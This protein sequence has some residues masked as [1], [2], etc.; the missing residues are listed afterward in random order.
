MDSKYLEKVKKILKT[1]TEKEA[2][3]KIAE[4]DLKNNKISQS[5]YEAAIE[6]I[7]NKNEKFRIR[8]ARRFST[9]EEAEKELGIKIEGHKID[10][11]KGLE[12]DR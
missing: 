1:N 12:M 4:N 3:R 9:K 10:E 11:I 6:L 2:I 8:I 5:E 7:E